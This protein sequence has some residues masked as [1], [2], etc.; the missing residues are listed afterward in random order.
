MARSILRALE[1][2]TE[3]GFAFHGVNIATPCSMNVKGKYLEY[4]PGPKITFCDLRD[5]FSSLVNSNIKSAGKPA[6]PAKY[7]APHPREGEMGLF[8]H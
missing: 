3:N 4:R 5:R 8:I 2:P 6:K 1:S 7:K